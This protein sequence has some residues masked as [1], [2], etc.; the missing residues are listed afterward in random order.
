M[1]QRNPELILYHGKITTLDKQKP[2]VSAVALS[3][4]VVKA[5]GNDAEILQLAGKIFHSE[6]NLESIETKLF[7]IWIKPRTTHLK[8]SW[9]T[10][11]FPK[12]QTDDFLSLLVSGDGAAPLTINQDARIFAGNLGQNKSVSHHLKSNAY[13]VVTKGQLLVNDIKLNQG[14]GAE[15]TD[16][17]AV[18][19]HALAESNLLLI[20]V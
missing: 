3:D 12:S 10:H 11:Q 2:E 5:I 4:G 14:D 6:Y 8:P 16:A 19:L 17:N 13:L 9:K 15:I 20:E 1:S 7:Q 18:T